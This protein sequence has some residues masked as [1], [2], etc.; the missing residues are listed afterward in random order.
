[1]TETI[2]TKRHEPIGV[3]EYVNQFGKKR[4]GDHVDFLADVVGTLYGG[5]LIKTSGM[6]V[7]VFS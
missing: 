3:L 7:F 5:G 1:M 4:I 6:Y 2:V